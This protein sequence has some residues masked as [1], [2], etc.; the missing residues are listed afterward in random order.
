MPDS[1]TPPSPSPS[2][3]E[4]QRA[5]AG[6]VLLR[7]A[8]ALVFG[9]VTVFW[10]TP[11]A[12]GGA[13][14]L[15]AY[16]VGLAVARTW[17]L[18]RQG[19]AADSAARP[20]GSARVVASAAY[21]VAAAV[22]LGL[23]AAPDTVVIGIGAAIA[24]AA[25]GLADLA[26]GLAFRVAG[27]RRSPLARDEVITGVVHLGAAIL[28]PF[29]GALGAHALLGVAGG[30]AIITGVLLVIAGLSLRHDSPATAEVA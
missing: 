10:G 22:G 5:L 20:S 12:F 19:R 24:F 21:G 15:A 3:D 27:Q 28:L 9:A 18:R 1:P 2:G 6:P 16:F 26:S 23:A 11:T 29:F 17:L 25:T 4:S 13:W 7:G 8:I 14:C 30:A